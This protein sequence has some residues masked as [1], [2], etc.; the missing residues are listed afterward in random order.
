[1]KIPCDR[2][3]VL[4]LLFLSVLAV[5][6]ARRYEV[7]GLV[8]DVNPDKQTMIVSHEAVPGYMGAM[9]MPFRV[10]RSEEIASL[11]PG[12]AVQFRLTV[13]QH[14][15]YAERV[16]R[17]KG[18]KRDKRPSQPELALEKPKE[19]LSRGAQVPDFDLLDQR[20]RP[21]HLHDFRG[22]IVLLNFIYTRCPLPEVC[23]RLAASFARI[24][25]RFEPRMGKDMVLLSITMD[26][27]YDTPTVLAAYARRWGAGPDWRFLTGRLE[28]VERIARGF[29]LVYWPEE[30]LLTHTSQTAI[31]GR[32]G[33][34]AAL[35]EGSSFQDGQMMDLVGRQLEGSL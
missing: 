35:V 15:S 17:E 20:G 13:T 33:R 14:A 4:L 25:E 9:A 1:M 5:S 12:D 23:P 30:G 7:H 28:T 34:L 29:G 24:Q 26:P 22:K 6:C 27:Q 16:E 3:S 11:Q 19:A 2:L 8:L 32:D 31:V 10:R 21:V 18:T